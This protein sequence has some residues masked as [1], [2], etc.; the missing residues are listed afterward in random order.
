MASIARPALVIRRLRAVCE[1]C[2]N[3]RVWDQGRIAREQLR[4]GLKSPEDL[5]AQLR[6]RNCQ[7]RGRAARNVT[8]QF[9]Y[10]D[11]PPGAYIDRRPL[12]EI[13]SVVAA[14]CDCGHRNQIDRAAL[15]ALS[16]SGEATTVEALWRQA[17]CKP[18]RD[19]G[20]TEPNVTLETDPPL[21]SQ[22]KPVDAL[23]KWSR[24]EVFG[25]NRSDPFPTLR[26]SSFFVEEGS[27][28]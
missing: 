24:A 1:D 5:L 14:C 26:R 3:R 13:N 4:R 28:P 27:T 12:V 9:E 23:V 10:V 8:A 22:G 7:D 11:A 15:E 6:C 25:E 21:P 2:G 18:C 19:E 17:F 20:S 16:M